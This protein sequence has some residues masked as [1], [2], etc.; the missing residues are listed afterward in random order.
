MVG[1]EIEGLAVLRDG[2]AAGVAE[3]GGGIDQVDAACFPGAEPG[4][5]VDGPGVERGAV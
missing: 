5:Q 3:R 1:I 2:A 4:A